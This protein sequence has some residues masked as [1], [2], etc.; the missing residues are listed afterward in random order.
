MFPTVKEERKVALATNASV[1]IDLALSF[2]TVGDIRVR[3]GNFPNADPPYLSVATTY[4]IR[5][6]YA[7]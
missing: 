5:R 7:T 6:Q 2:P 1:P 4:T 3:V